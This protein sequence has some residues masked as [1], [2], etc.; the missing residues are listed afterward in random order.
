MRK[1]VIALCLTLVLALGLFAGCG[2]KKNYEVLVN[3]ANGA[4]V[5]G[6][7]IQFCSDTECAMATTD[8]NGV[9]VFEKE[10]GTYTIHVLTVP[11]GYAAD[12]TEY[13]AP[14]EPG[15]VTIVLAAAE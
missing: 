3:D 14:A 7:N 13:A 11:E 4:P 10:A 5:S 12:S 15:Q 6:V 2:G 1:K 9:A 8:A